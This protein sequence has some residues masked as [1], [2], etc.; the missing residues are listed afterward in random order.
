MELPLFSKQ[1]KDLSYASIKF[2]YAALTEPS[3]YKS[4]FDIHQK[5]KENTKQKRKG[6]YHD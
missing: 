6:S 4:D 5:K 2:Q 1:F 3:S